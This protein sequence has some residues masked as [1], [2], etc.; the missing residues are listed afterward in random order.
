MPITKGEAVRKC[1]ELWEE[2]EKS[3]D[4]KYGFLSSSDGERWMNERYWGSCPLCEYAGNKSASLPS[5]SVCPLVT[6]YGKMCSGLGFS[7]FHKCSP[8]WFKII[9]GLKE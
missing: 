3:G 6:Q 5:C 8:E 9:R 2:I 4:T 7:D 1:K